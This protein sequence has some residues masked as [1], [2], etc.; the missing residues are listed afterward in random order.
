MNFYSIKVLLKNQIEGRSNTFKML[1]SRDAAIQLNITKTH[2]N[3]KLLVEMKG[4]KF[5]IMLQVTFHKKVE[6]DE[7][8]VFTTNLFQ[9]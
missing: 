9:L 6:N 5:Q 4:F 3:N 2:V 1:K 7:K 8:K